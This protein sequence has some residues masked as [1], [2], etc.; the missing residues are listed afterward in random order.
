MRVIRF[1]SCIGLSDAELRLS[2]VDFVGFLLVSRTWG[3]GFT[4]LKLCKFLS[5]GFGA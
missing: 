1:S 2:N 4:G 5:S 3:P